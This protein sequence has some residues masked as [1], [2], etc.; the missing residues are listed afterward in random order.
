MPSLVVILLKIIK[1][2][3]VCLFG[4]MHMSSGVRGGQKK[5]ELE[6]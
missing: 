1:W 2:V 3:C 6:L 5:V 4:Y